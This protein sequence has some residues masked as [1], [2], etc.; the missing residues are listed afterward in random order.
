M[1]SNVCK[2][3]LTLIVETKYKTNTLL[4]KK[5]SKILITIEIQH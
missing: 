3:S 4:Q 2:K 5:I 1:H